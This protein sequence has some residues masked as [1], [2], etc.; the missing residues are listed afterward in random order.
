MEEG[1]Q[2]RAK[3]DKRHLGRNLNRVLDRHAIEELMKT[4]ED[5]DAKE[6]RVIP[7]T[8]K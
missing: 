6:K 3:V 2:I 4:S 1:Q 8:P 7:K 5:K